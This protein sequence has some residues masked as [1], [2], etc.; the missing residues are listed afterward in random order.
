MKYT[1]IH[2]VNRR[3]GFILQQ[4]NTKIVMQDEH[5]LR[6]LLADEQDLKNRWKELPKEEI[7]GKTPS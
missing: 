6:Y 5:G 7:N 1:H 4:T 2:Q 3:P